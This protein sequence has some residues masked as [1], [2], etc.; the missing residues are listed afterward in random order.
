MKMK[1]SKNNPIVPKVHYDNLADVL[2][3]DLDTEEPSNSKHLN[4][5]VILDIGIFS[6]LPT[7]VRILCPAEMGL[8]SLKIEIRKIHKAKAEFPEIEPDFDNR[9]KTIEELTKPKDIEKLIAA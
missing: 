9:I 5:S 3:I 7:G 1:F 4:D 6:N 8:K 2:Y